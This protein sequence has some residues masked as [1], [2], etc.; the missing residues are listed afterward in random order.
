MK[1]LYPY[2]K[3]AIS[4]S[5]DRRGTLLAAAMG[6]GKT[7]IASHCILTWL[8]S[9]PE[10]QR[11]LIVVPASVK[12]N[13]LLEFEEWRSGFPIGVDVTIG[14]ADGKT[15]PDANIVVIN[16]DLLHRDNHQEALFGAPWDI[17]VLDESTKIKNKSLRTKAVLSLKAK[18]KMCLTGTPIE[19]G[20]PI[21]LWNALTWLCPDKFSNWKWFTQRY[22]DAKPGWGSST[23]VS[24][25]SNEAELHRLLKETVMFR[26]TKEEAL[27]FLPAIQRQIIPLPAPEKC[28]PLIDEQNRIW[29]LHEA[30]IAKLREQRE[31]ARKN[32]NEAEYKEAAGKL[33]DTFSAAMSAMSKIR[34]ALGDAKVPIAIQHIEDV[35]EQVDKVVVFAHHK[36]VMGAVADHFQRYGALM[37]DGSVDPAER[38]PIVQ[39]F[40]KPEHRIIV[41]SN[42][43]AGMGINGLQVANHLVQLE[44]DWTPAI[45]SQIESRLHRNGQLNSVLVQHL[46]FD[47][48]LDSRMVKRCIDKQEV[49]NAIVDGVQSAEPTTVPDARTPQKRD[50]KL[51]GSNMPE[52]ERASAHAAIRHIARMDRDGARIANGAGFSKVD[53][54]T[55]HTLAALES[56]TPAQY[57]LMREIVFKYRNQLPPSMRLDLLPKE[58]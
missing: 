38:L 17:I 1:P 25:S 42:T 55:G 5:T 31:E 53:S 2:Q 8:A 47:D 20:K 7:A 29:T 54:Q 9:N 49:A 21:E 11:V 46:V 10:W 15:F 32:S 35:L 27:P 14:I 37:I 57:A 45:N 36:S 39:A 48:S 50:Y 19:N 51:I 56:P 13:W 3:G 12:A 43:A 33:R 23:D 44:S 34:K 52:S 40:A 4:F 26:I 22:C 6:T 28:K 16:Y 30:T 58:Q 41:C 18:R 24:G